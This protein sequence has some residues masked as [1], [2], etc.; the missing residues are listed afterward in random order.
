MVDKFAP[1]EISGMGKIIIGR[2]RYFKQRGPLSISLK[3]LT[4][5]Q[6]KRKRYR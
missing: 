4:C 6:C 2:F 5:M 1:K 3:T